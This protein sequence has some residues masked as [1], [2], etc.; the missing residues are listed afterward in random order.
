MPYQRRRVILVMVI[1]NDFKNILSPYFLIS[2][3]NV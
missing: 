1:T 3:L 2:D